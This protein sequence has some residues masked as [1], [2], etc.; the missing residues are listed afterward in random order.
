ML[1]MSSRRYEHGGAAPGR[2]RPHSCTAFTVATRQFSRF[3]FAWRQ[4]LRRCADSVCDTLTR[5]GTVQMQPSA[6]AAARP[7]YP[8]SLLLVDAQH[9][10]KRSSRPSSRLLC[11]SLCRLC[12]KGRSPPRLPYDPSPPS[13][14]CRRG[15][16][17]CAASCLLRL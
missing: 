14:Q 13:Q 1:N 16:S 2:R 15:G 7:V 17:S 8:R 11:L 5:Q 6:R 12:P 9:L 4:R 10:L 3:S